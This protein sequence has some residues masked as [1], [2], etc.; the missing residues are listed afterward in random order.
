MDKV[1]IVIQGIWYT[2][3]DTLKA[4]TSKEGSFKEDIWLDPV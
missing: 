1:P 3:T 4:I 2:I